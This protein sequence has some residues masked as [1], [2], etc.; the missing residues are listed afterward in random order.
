MFA[1]YLF[2]LFLLLLLPFKFSFFAPGIFITYFS[3]R[4]FFSSSLSISFSY[5]FQFAVGLFKYFHF[6]FTFLFHLAFARL[7]GFPWRVLLSP[8][9]NLVSFWMT[10]FYSVSSNSII[11]YF[12]ILAILFS[13]F[14][15]FHEKFFTIEMTFFDTRN[16]HVWFIFGDFVAVNTKIL[17]E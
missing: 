6:F 7:F 5:L 12:S 11:F 17:A 2:L 10:F 3:T 9:A 13:I 4:T 1:F 8:N 14:F 15:F 16:W